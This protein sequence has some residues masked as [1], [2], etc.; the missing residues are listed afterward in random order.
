MSASN[1]VSHGYAC[2]SLQPIPT[3]QREYLARDAKRE[4]EEPSRVA[5]RSWFFSRLSHT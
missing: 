3:N 1:G 4:K 5:A 2:V